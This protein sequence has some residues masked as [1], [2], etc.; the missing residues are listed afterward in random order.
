MMLFSILITDIPTM[1]HQKVS[2]LCCSQRA[3][4]DKFCTLN[5]MI[6]GIIML[7]SESTFNIMF[8]LL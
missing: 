1:I 3:A 7:K 2:L 5:M 4:V 6:K 8:I